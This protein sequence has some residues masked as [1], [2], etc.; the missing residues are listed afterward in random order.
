MPATVAQILAEVSALRDRD[1]VLTQDVD[2]IKA[3]LR[4]LVA[5]RACVRASMKPLM[6]KLGR[7][8]A[9]ELRKGARQLAAAGGGDAQ[10]GAV[11][12]AVRGGRP[13]LPGCV[14]CR[15]LARG[16]RG[17]KP[18]TCTPAERSA[19]RQARERARA[20]GVA[21]RVVKRTGL[22]ATK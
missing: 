11:K 19:A 15:F 6:A 17:G 16:G 4:V 1:A 9:V 10:R 7:R 22:K 2:S 8:S 21:K 3:K 14:Q 18:H 5:E 13:L 12:A 20:R